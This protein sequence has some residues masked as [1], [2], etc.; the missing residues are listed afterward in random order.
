MICTD[1]LCNIDKICDKGLD[2]E[3]INNSLKQELLIGKGLKKDRRHFIDIARIR[4][5]GGR[6]GAFDKGL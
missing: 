1:E 4:Q 2:K 3:C 5:R 6:R